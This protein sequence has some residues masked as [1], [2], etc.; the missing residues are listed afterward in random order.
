MKRKN[1]LALLGAGVLGL[2]M[3]GFVGCDAAHA[4]SES[5]TF[6]EAVA[7]YAAF[8][9]K[10]KTEKN[11]TMDYNNPR[12]QSF[13]YLAEFAEDKAKITGGYGGSSYYDK[14]GSF[15]LKKDNVTYYK[16]T[17]DNFN[18]DV[19]F[20]EEFS[21]FEKVTWES[22]S[23]KTNMLS[24]KVNDVI[25]GWTI[26]NNVKD[27]VYVTEKITAVLN[28][29]GAEIHAGI[30]SHTM[31]TIKIYNIGTTVVNLPEYIIYK[32]FAQ[33]KSEYDAFFDRLKTEKNFTLEFHDPND[34][35]AC[36]IA[37]INGDMGKITD[38]YGNP[39]FYDAEGNYD[40]EN[41]QYHRN[42]NNI[43]AQLKIIFSIFDMVDYFGWDS[44]SA[45]ENKLIGTT[46]YI[47]SWDFDDTITYHYTRAN[48]TAV[49]N[50]NNAE[51]RI[52]AMGAD[53]M[54]TVTVHHIG[55]TVVNLP[56]GYIDDAV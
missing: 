3:L 31:D 28:N 50:E 41:G 19:R 49:I 55:T 56:Q 47:T 32:T 39:T 53:S 10:L 6:E 29:D 27:Y 5:K 8:I 40:T 14:E 35:S 46:L 54:N 33:A 18:F 22:Y 11:F 38:G 17:D 24:G 2:A 4:N 43:E 45:D 42:H 34:Q 13:C 16:E 20:R 21:N 51:I 7:E 37:E 26:E 1:L 44:Y 30:G 48:I 36:Y 23:A 15:K 12:E 52:G 25:S 9:D